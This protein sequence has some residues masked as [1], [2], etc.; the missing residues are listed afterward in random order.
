LNS[1]PAVVFDGLDLTGAGGANDNSQPAPDAD[2][3]HLPALDSN[4]TE[5]LSVFAVSERVDSSNACRPMFQ[6]ANGLEKDDIQLAFYRQSILYEVLNQHINDA[7]YPV[8]VGVPLIVAAVQP[9]FGDTHVT[10]NGLVAA[11]PAPLGLPAQVTRSL[12]FLGLSPGDCGNF[13]G[14]LSELLLYN[15][16]VTALEVSKIQSYLQKHWGCCN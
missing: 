6:A 2:W 11:A 5:G 14:P 8:P 13:K 10:L 7:A 15:R 3:M 4:F 1:R 12:A 9:T 16:E